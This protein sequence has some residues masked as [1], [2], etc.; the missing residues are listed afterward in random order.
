MTPQLMRDY[1]RCLVH[2]G[3]PADHEAL[4]EILEDLSYRHP[5]PDVAALVV[6]GLARAYR[7][8]KA[9]GAAMQ[10]ERRG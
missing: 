7:I 1:A 8:G 10:G 2:G 4:I 5:D 9:D 3:S 6:E